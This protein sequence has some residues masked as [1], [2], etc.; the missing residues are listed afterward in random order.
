MVILLDKTLRIREKIK[1]ISEPSALAPGKE[2]SKHPYLPVFLISAFP[3]GYMEEGLL[4]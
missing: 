1:E 3:L 2:R 4:G